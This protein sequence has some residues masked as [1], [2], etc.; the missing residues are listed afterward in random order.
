MSGSSISAESRSAPRWKSEKIK[1]P[2][3]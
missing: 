1:K 2:A 3:W